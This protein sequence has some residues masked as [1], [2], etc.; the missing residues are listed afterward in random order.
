M[1]FLKIKK[2]VLRK[3]IIEQQILGVSMK[4]PLVFLW[5]E[6]MIIKEGKPRENHGWRQVLHLVLKAEEEQLF[7]S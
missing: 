5:S 4:V 7:V 6:V 2:I 1:N 3:I